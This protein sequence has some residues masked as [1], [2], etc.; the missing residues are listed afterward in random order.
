MSFNASRERKFGVILS[1]VSIAVSYLVAMLYTPVTL[2]LLGQSEYGLYTLSSTMVNYLTLL[3]FGMGASYVR[4]YSKFKKDKERVDSLNSLYVLV[5]SAIGFIAMFVGA[6]LVLNADAMFSATLTVEEIE[7]TK[8][9]MV[10]LII[11]MAVSFPASV[12]SSFLT[13]NER[14]VVLRIIQILKHV[15][16]PL[17]VLPLLLLGYASIA[18]TVVF[19]LVNL[20]A[21]T[22]YFV[23]AVKKVKMSFSRKYV[24]WGL[25]KEI[26]TFSFFIFLNSIVNEINWNLG[27]LLLGIFKGTVAVAIYGVAAQINT[28]YIS[29][30]TA[31]S[32]VYVPKVNQIISATNDSREINKLFVK[33]GRI[34]FMI[35]TLIVIGFIFI[36]KPFVLLWAGE[37]YEEAYWIILILI[38]PELIPLTQNLGIEIQ[39]A[40]N[41]HQFRAIIYTI[42][43]VL[44]LLMSIPLGKMYGGIGCAIGTAFGQIVGNTIIMNWYYQKALDIDIKDYWKNILGIFPAL[45]IPVI[46]GIVI[47]NIEILGWMK[48][49]GAGLAIVFSYVVSMWFFGM[50]EDEKNMI[51]RFAR[52][53]R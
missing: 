26:G 17:I 1:Y 20:A 2:R 8:I 43:A 9:I 37:G 39:R 10:I 29:M 41:K 5:F 24:E 14:F 45:I 23:Y 27:K 28:V 16:N 33:I 34:Q 11:N 19:F 44:N 38:I 53:C 42:I 48:L 13:A 36:G 3:S 25:L 52:I 51:L 12:F 18:M 4:F 47:L 31:V 50:N 35:Q 49:L 21:D 46:V 6:I 15:L 32:N 40:K 30:S 22:F 7:K